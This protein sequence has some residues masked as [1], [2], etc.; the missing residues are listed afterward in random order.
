MPFAGVSQAGGNLN[1]GINAGPF[2]WNL[3][4]AASNTNWN[5][6]ARLLFRSMQFYGANNP[7]RLVKIMSQPDRL[8]G[9]RR[10][11]IRRNKSLIKLNIGDGLIQRIGNVFDD[12]KISIESCRA[13]II[14][15]AQGKHSRRSVQ[16][17]L[18]NVDSYACKL[19]DMLLNEQYKPS[20]YTACRIVDRPSGKERILH[21]PVFFP[22]QCVH[23]VVMSLIQDAVMHKLDPYTCGSIPGRGQR[24]GHLAIRRWLKNDRKNTKY[25]YK[26]D[27][28]K[29]YQSVD[30]G[31]LK[32]TL[33][34]WFKDQKLLR[35]LNVIIDSHDEGL[36]LGNYTSSWLANI[37]LTG[38]DRMIRAHPAAKYYIRYVDDICI[39]GPNKR[40]LHRLH[41]A[42]QEY[43]TSINLS[44]KGNWQVFP[45]SVRGVD[46]LGCRYFRGY[47]TMRKRNA[48]AIM[49]Q[50]RKIRTTQAQGKKVKYHQAAGYLS[51]IGQLKHC[52]SYNF[53][54][55]YISNIQINKLK[56]V[57]RNE[58]G[59]HGNAGRGYRNIPNGG[60]NLPGQAV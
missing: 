24:K 49:R 21:K 56:E 51:R 28:S 57:V 40:K 26:A 13:A 23:H 19:R 29:F 43:L 54:C 20:P 18:Q 15:A 9:L 53:R 55:K 11:S 41:D 17:V 44:V 45:V 48:L 33:T 12:K 32:A 37:M 38:L 39:F 31:K 1:N 46:M 35:L 4:N 2:Y 60:R 52:N 16:V 14:K 47:T 58:N 36:P 7:Y 6:G 25:C 59:N 10:T 50:T 30:H 27:V 5:I 8:V 22:D 3:N 34:K 42:V